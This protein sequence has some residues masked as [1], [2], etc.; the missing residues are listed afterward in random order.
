MPLLLNRALLVFIRYGNSFGGGKGRY[1]FN[2][3]YGLWPTTVSSRM[4]FGWDVTWLPQL[5]VP[6]VNLLVNLSSMFCMIAHSL[7]LFGLGLHPAFYLKFLCIISSGMAYWN[8]VLALME[9][10]EQ[11]FVSSDFNRPFNEAARIL[12][13]SA[14]LNSARVREDRVLPNAASEWRLIRWERPP[15]GWLKLNSD[16]ATRGNPGLAG[17]GGI[18]QDEHGNWISGFKHNIGIVSL[19][20]TEL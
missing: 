7:G 13:V 12:D 10:A 14:N 11:E 6:V 9:L 15:A 8:C 19:T 2:I 5:F 16:G 4:I 1:L 18:I 20:T 17:A 3:F